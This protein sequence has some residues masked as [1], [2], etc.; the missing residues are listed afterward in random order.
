MN[1]EI[2]THIVY[3][4]VL[5]LRGLACIAG[6]DPT[7]FYRGSNFNGADLRGE[8]L[9]GFCLIGCS[10]LGAA[11]DQ[12]TIVDEEFKHLLFMQKGRVKYFNRTKGFGFIESDNGGADIFVHITAV[13]RAGLRKLEVDQS[14][15]YN[16]E[17]KNGR[18]AAVNIQLVT[19]AS[20]EHDVNCLEYNLLDEVDVS[21]N[22][23]NLLTS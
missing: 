5:D 22:E 13:E 6:G 9:R 4:S 15:T 12:N 23:G 10:F 17:T 2:I 19:G 18:S 7:N 20:S 14:L 11:I 1:A 8:D 3:S 16:V 21:E